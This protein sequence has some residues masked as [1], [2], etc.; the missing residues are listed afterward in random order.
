MIKRANTEKLDASATSF[1]FQGFYFFVPNPSN[2][3][4]IEPKSLARFPSAQ[5]VSTLLLFYALANGSK[6]DSCVDRFR[7][8]V[9]YPAHGLG[10]RIQKF[11]PRTTGFRSSAHVAVHS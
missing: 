6:P 8:E 7:R 9:D 10:L 3:F 11:P 4:R 5:P 1:A 2:A